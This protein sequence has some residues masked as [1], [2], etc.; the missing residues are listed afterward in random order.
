MTEIRIDFPRCGDEVF[1]EPTGETWLVAWADGDEI[2]WCGWP[3]GIA[4]V[5]DCRIVSHATEAQHR[6]MVLEVS[7]CDDSR[8]PKCARLYGAHLPAPP[9]ETQG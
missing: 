2:A 3:N 1:H 6:R 8:G 4:R 9:Q 5:Q 7:R